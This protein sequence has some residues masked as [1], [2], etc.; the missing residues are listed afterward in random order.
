MSVLVWIEQDQSDHAL[1]EQL[2][3]AGQGAR[4]RAAVGR[5]ARRSRAG[6]RHRGNCAEG[7]RLRRR[8]RLHC[9]QPHSRHFPPERIRR[10]PQGRGGSLRRNNR[11]CRRHHAG[12]ELT[13]YLA[14]ELGA[15]I[16]P[17]AVD[18]R[19][20]D[21]KLVAVRS[22]YSNNIL[23]DVTFTSPVQVASVRPRSFP[24][25]ASRAFG[26]RHPSCGCRAE[27]SQCGREGH[28]VP[29]DGNG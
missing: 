25:P 1:L 21:G 13:A 9:R 14:F 4:T 8:R 2:G 6:R 3:S 12:R 15:G 18:L 10:S 17:D 24:A 27:R 28:R 19:I 7:D 5:Q 11:P 20:E 22:I 26:W 16:A 23:T 29:L